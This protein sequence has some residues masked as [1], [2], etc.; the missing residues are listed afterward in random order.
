MTVPRCCTQRWRCLWAVML[1]LA[2]VPR[3]HKERQ[4]GPFGLHSLSQG[5]KLHGSMAG[6]RQSCEKIVG[7]SQFANR[8]RPEHLW[9]AGIGSS[10]ASA[11]TSCVAGQG[12]SVLREQWRERLDEVPFRSSMKPYVSRKPNDPYKQWRKRL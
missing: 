1:A 6:G 12:L 8:Q 2:R 10:A 4:R 3:V 11:S 9:P 5:A 7:V